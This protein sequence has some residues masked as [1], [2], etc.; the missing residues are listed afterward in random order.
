MIASNLEYAELSHC[1]LPFVEC[2][3]FDHCA[4]ARD[5]RFGL[6]VRAS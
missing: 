3:I 5:I 2:C 1:L 6:F 4:F